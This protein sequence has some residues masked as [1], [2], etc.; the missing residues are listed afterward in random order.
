T[1][2][3]QP[4]ERHFGVTR[5]ILEAFSR[6]E[7][8]ELSITTKS[9]LILRDQELLVALDR[10]H[11]VTAQIT[12][13]TLDHGLARRLEQRAPDP[14][15]RLGIVRRLSAAG[16]RTQVL[17]MPLM[18]GI[19][20]REDVLAPLFAAARDAGASDVLASPLF[21]RRA[22]RDRFMPWLSSEFPDLE[23]TYRRLY[24]RRDYLSS[25]ARDRLL[26]NFRHLRVLYGFPRNQL[27]RG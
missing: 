23:P 25:D 17:C 3:Y 4:A 14:S 22:A 16:I 24:S 7:G 13:T 19:N 1:D 26:E 18:P 20:D 15:S 9:P 21:L 12:I 8:L 5:S 2:P 11:S 27:G 10:A 6:A